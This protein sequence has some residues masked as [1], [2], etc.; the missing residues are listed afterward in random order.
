M[1]DCSEEKILFAPS[2]KEEVKKEEA[3]VKTEEGDQNQEVTLEKKWIPERLMAIRKHYKV[4]DEEVKEGEEPDKEL[5]K[6]EYLVQWKD[7]CLDD[8]TWESKKTIESYGLGL[9]EK[10]G[11]DFSESQQLNRVQPFLSIDGNLRTE[12]TVVPL[13][14]SDKTAKISGNVG[15]IAQGDV[16]IRATNIKVMD[17]GKYIRTYWKERENGVTPLPTWVYTK[18]FRNSEENLKFLCYALLDQAKF[19]SRRSQRR[20]R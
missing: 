20:A 12:T 17:G 11:I 8:S 9:I 16:P 10:F 5:L 19:S 1:S 4:I 13:Y 15:S 14:G 3:P 7:S 2:A 6:K 18:D